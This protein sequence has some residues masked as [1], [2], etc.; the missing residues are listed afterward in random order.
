MRSINGSLDRRI[1][2]TRA[3]A[4]APRPPRRGTTAGEPEG[5]RRRRT[6]LCV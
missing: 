5:R 3:P 6:R 4:P 2:Y 1:F